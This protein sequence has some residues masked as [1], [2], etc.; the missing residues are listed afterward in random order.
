MVT[1]S[2]SA[3]DRGRRRLSRWGTEKQQRARREGIGFEGAA[4]FSQA[5]AAAGSR[6]DRLQAACAAYCGG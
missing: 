6:T 2:R 3:G 5:A 1:M 4:C